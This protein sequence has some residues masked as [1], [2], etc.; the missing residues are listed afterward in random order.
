MKMFSSSRMFSSLPFEQ[1]EGQT[2]HDTYTS[3]T[4]V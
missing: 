3:R 2:L 4:I 1:N